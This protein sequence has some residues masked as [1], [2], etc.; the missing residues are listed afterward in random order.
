MTDETSTLI[1]LVLLMLNKQYVSA[2]LREFF[3]LDKADEHSIVSKLEI[4][5]TK[6]DKL[7]CL[8]VIPD[9]EWKEGESVQAYYRHSKTSHEIGIKESVYEKACEGQPFAV[10]TFVHETA[11]WGLINNFNHCLAKWT[12][13]DE[14]GRRSL[15]RMHESFADVISVILL[16]RDTGKSYEERRNA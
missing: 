1:A 16:Y 8:N 12:S 4:A 11:H 9:N 6:K 2:K 5:M 13:L 15:R 10:F 14:K 3:K 7:F